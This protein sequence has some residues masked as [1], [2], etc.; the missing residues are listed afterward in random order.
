MDNLNIKGVSGLSALSNYARCKMYFGRTVKVK[1]RN[2]NTYVGKIVKLDGK[3]VYLKV[4]SVRSGQEV[5]TSFFPFI[6]PLV[7]FDL[8]AIV[9]LI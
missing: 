2:G 8:L 1:S 3:K 4:K 9:L 6:L 5:H 7:L